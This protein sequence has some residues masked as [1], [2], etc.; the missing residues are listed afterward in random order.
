MDIKCNGR[1]LSPE[2]PFGFW[3]SVAKE[4]LP[5][6]HMAVTE[7]PE[8]DETTKAIMDKCTEKTIAA[9]FIQ[10]LCQQPIDVAA[11]IRECRIIM[12]ETK[13]ESK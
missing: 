4:N 9:S 1:H 13:N 10:S 7:L 11:V 3:Q 5:D 6:S 2:S 12:K 8:M